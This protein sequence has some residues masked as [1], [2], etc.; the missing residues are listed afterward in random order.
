MGVIWLDK[1][2]FFEAA[3]KR[4]APA[5]TVLDIG[6]G[7]RPQPY[8]RPLVHICCEPFEPYLERLGKTLRNEHDRSYLLLKATW[9]EAVRLFPPKSVDTVFLV[10][11]V[12]HL[13]KEEAVALLDQTAGIV[14]RQVALFT[15]LG[16]CPQDP[17]GG[18]DA[19][20]LDG[21]T[22]QTHRSGWSPEDFDESWEVFATREFHTRDNRGNSLEKSFGALWAIRTVAEE[23]RAPGEEPSL[24]EKIRTI[25]DIAADNAGEGL[26]L[27]VRLMRLGERI[28]ASKTCLFLYRVLS[29]RGRS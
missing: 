7:I 19:W 17:D 14:R 27:F 16:F 20:G 5:E 26:N 2:A 6:C 8:L 4:L 3:L 12:E 22:W 28:K 24:K 21:G 13:E 10:D 23:G 11:V 29:G 25:H 18:P 9:A 15:P 1:E